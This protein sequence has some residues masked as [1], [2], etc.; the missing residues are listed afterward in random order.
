MLDHSFLDLFLQSWD[1]FWVVDI[2]T[3]I[4]KEKSFFEVMMNSVLWKCMANACCIFFLP[5]LFP[6]KER[7]KEHFL[8]A[9]HMNLTALEREE[10]AMRFPCSPSKAPEQTLE[11]CV[12][13]PAFSMSSLGCC[14]Q[15]GLHAVYALGAHPYGRDTWAS[16]GNCSQVLLAVFSLTRSGGC[17]GSA[18]LQLLWCPCLVLSCAGAAC[19][20]PAFLA[21]GLSF[22]EKMGTVVLCH[23]LVNGLLWIHVK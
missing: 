11:H 7:S 20:C 13:C 23:I 12:K 10:R 2:R 3:W 14:H 19:A 21:K 1:G 15:R 22:K 16:P 18:A 17:C 4:D 9:A 8:F 6:F 5:G